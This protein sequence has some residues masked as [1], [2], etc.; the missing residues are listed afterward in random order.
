MNPTLFKHALFPLF[1]TLHIPRV[2][3]LPY[4][5]PRPRTFAIYVGKVHRI[6][7]CVDWECIIVYV[8]DIPTLLQLAKC[9]PCM[10]GLHSWEQGQ[11]ST[12]RH[13]EAAYNRDPALRF[14]SLFAFIFSRRSGHVGQ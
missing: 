10:Q 1:R 3:M 4:V 5:V 14:C 7:V 11:Y 2:L 9:I 8:Y 6:M 12:V 13:R